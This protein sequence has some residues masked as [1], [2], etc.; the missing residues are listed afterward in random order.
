MVSTL[1]HE[2]EHIIIAIYQFI[3][4]TFQFSIFIELHLFLEV[5]NIFHFLFYF[6]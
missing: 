4:H 2:L 5:H 6:H 1:I 3:I